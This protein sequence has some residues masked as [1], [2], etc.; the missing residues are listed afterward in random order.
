MTKWQLIKKVAKNYRAT[1]P[2]PVTIREAVE[3]A[4]DSVTE[5]MQGR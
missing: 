1:I 3:A 5:Y 2:F 4:N